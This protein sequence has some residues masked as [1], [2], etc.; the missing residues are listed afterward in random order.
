M[1]GEHTNV[2]RLATTLLEPTHASVEQVT[3]WLLM[4][5]IALVCLCVVQVQ[6]QVLLSVID[7]CCLF[8]RNWGGFG[9][10]LLLTLVMS[11]VQLWNLYNM[12]YRIRAVSAFFYHGLGITPHACFSLSLGNIQ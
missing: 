8:K 11:G 10:W 5:E 1:T 4:G 9:T 3:D 6:L 12:E 7:W 2:A